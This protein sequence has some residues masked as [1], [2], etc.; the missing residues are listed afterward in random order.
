MLT[1]GVGPEHLGTTWATDV[2]RLMP[3]QIVSMVNHD[4]TERRHKCFEGE[5]NWWWIN[6][7]IR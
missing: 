6:D 3:D 4:S 7:I 2:T 5:E 1:E